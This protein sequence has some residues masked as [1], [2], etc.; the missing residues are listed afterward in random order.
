[1]TAD[2]GAL[3]DGG[4]LDGPRPDLSIGPAHYLSRKGSQLSI[5]VMRVNH[6]HSF[7]H[8]VIVGHIG[9]GC[10]VRIHSRCFYGDSLASDDCDCG[11]Q[12]AWSMDQIQIEGSGVLF[13]LEQEGRG[14]GLVAK[15]RAYH[16]SQ[17]LGLNTFESYEWLGFPSDSR[18]YGQVAV[19]LRRLGL[20]SIRLLTNNP[21]KVAELEFEGIRVTRVPVAVDL[22]ND[23]VREYVRVK[24]VRGHFCPT[25]GTS[26][27]SG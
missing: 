13:Y 17:Q 14:E 11:A 23:V 5:R 19:T 27:T 7:G 26:G 20:A 4:H 1:M 12:L 24:Q 10:L 3:P 16:V 25:I 9:D 21:A 8:A 2:A 15:S 6:D 22:P 18:S